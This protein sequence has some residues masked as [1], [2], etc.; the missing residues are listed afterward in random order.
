MVSTQNALGPRLPFST[1][2]TNCVVTGVVWVGVTDTVG[3]DSLCT[4]D[5]QVLGS[6]QHKLGTALKP[7]AVGHPQPQ[8][9]VWVL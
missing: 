7:G 8:G 6:A 4:F 9:S 1:L 5:N 2:A 3:T